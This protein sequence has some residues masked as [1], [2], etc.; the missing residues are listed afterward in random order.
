M[1]RTVKHLLH[2]LLRIRGPAERRGHA[3]VQI[4][5]EAREV[6][7]GN[8][9]PDPVIRLEGV[10][11]ESGDDG[12]RREKAHTIVPKGRHALIFVNSIF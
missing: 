4:T 6:A 5:V 7:A 1:R 10:V 11:G 9:Q 3:R 12:V 2:R 8:L